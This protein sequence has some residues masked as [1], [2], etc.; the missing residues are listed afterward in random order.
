V[1]ALSAT[2][3]SVFPTIYVSDLAGSFNSLLF[4]TKQPTTIDN[5]LANYINLMQDETTPPLLLEVLA[6][7]YEG[8]QPVQTTSSLVFTDD[9]APVEHITNSII[10]N[11]LVSEE[12]ESLK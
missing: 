6:A 7:T 10:V 11:F 1:D 12:T 9:R 4:A 3:R 8:M 2:I 5:F